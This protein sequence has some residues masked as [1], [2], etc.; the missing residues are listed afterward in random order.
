MTNSKIAEQAKS[1]PANPQSHE[2]RL[3]SEPLDMPATWEQLA[4]LL[5][6]IAQSAPIA[7]FLHDPD[8]NQYTLRWARDWVAQAE[9]GTNLDG[10]FARWL[11]AQGQPPVLIGSQAR[12]P[13]P[14][15]AHQDMQVPEEM[16][17][18]IPL[19]GRSDLLNPLQRESRSFSTSTTPLKQHTR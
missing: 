1:S 12:L 19:R 2:R 18:F 13:S 14:P 8:S 9:P 5:E 7:V 6:L 3:V 16:E 10:K 4:G 17:L 15:P 11:G